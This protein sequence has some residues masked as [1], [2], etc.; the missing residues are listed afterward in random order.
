MRRR[1]RTCGGSAPN[2]CSLLANEYRRI[3]RY[4]EMIECS[5]QALVVNRRIQ[6]RDG[7]ATALTNLGTANSIMGRQERAMEFFE[8]ALPSAQAEMWRQG[9]WRSPYYWAAFT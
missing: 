9:Q 6:N 3:S 8:Q 4:P 7:E 5:E 1:S 2:G